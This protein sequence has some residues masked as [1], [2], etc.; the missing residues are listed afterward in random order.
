MNK[1][2]AARLNAVVSYSCKK[3]SEEVEEAQ[4]IKLSLLKRN[5]QH[6]LGFENVASLG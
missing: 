1:L 2:F 6:S 5:K 3:N 4:K